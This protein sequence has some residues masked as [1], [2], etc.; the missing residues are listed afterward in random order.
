M[1]T[2]GLGAL[3]YLLL[4]TLII[5]AAS[6]TASDY[7]AFPPHG[8]SVRWFVRL[9]ALEEVRVAAGRS[10][11]IALAATAISVGLGVAAAFPLVRSRFPGREGLNA[12]LMSPLILPSPARERSVRHARL[13]EV[14]RRA[15]PGHDRQ[16]V[17][18][19]EDDLRLVA[20][21]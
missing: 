17:L 20:H 6:F 21:G 4:P 10:L 5:V 7:I 18:L 16:R 3:L 14:Q 1:W 13:R 11:L 15:L 8:L 12:F 9:W 2:L 19:R